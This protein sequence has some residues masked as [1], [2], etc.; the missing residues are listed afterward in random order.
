MHLS[1]RKAMYKVPNI[2]ATVEGVE[3]RIKNRLL[4]VKIYHGTKT[5]WT[6][7]I[8]VEGLKNCIYIR[9]KM[10]GL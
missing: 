1:G 5:K 9:K 2:Y 8:R 3:Y 7:W 6:E 4:E 10:R